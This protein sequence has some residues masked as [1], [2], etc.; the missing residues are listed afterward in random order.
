[1][2]LLV[3]SWAWGATAKVRHTTPVPT[4]AIA[5]PRS[6]IPARQIPSNQITP[7]QNKIVIPSKKPV[8]AVANKKPQK[9]IKPMT[10][11]DEILSSWKLIENPILE[12]S[13]RLGVLR[14]GEFWGPSPKAEYPS[15]FIF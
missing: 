9:K 5:A 14:E 11:D 2:V 15:Q 3:L 6:T 8:T 4:K 1:M 12:Y 7:T 13:V 10:I